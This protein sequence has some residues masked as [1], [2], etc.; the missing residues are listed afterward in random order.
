MMTG[1][2]RYVSIE[3]GFFGIVADNGKGYD[4]VNLPR[5]YAKDGLRIA[6]QAVPIEGG[7][8]IHMWGTIVRIVKITKL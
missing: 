5:E 3:G 6:F 1:T 7:V 8:S 4:P 2:V